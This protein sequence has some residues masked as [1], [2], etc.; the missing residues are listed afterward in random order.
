M[1]EPAVD[2][3]PAPETI[4]EEQTQTAFDMP[5]EAAAQIAEEAQIDMTAEAPEASEPVVEPTPEP[6]PEEVFAKGARKLPAVPIGK[7]VEDV[8]VTMD[9]SGN[10]S[11]IC[12]TRGDE[13]R[14]LTTRI[15]SEITA[16][17]HPDDVELWLFDCGDGEFDKYIDAPAEHIKYLISDA[18]AETSLDFADVIMSE[19]NSRTEK[20]AANNWASADDIPADVYMPRIVIAVNAFSRFIENIVKSP[21][22]FGR[23]YTSKL[24][25]MFKN[26][27]KYGV[28]FLLIGDEFSES[29]EFPSYF[30]GCTIDSAAVTS[31]NDQAAHKIFSGFKLYDNEIESLRRVPAGCAFTADGNSSDGLTLVRITGENAVNEHTYRQASEYSENVEEYLD[32]RPFI[33]GRKAASRFDDRR[34]Y[35]E[36]QI[37]NR[38]NGEYLLFLGEPNRFMGE[39][40]VH[41]YDDFGENIFAVAPAREKSSAALTVRAALRSL[42]E[43][44]VRT[45]VLAYRS[46]PVYAEL[47]QSDELAN[48]AVFEGTKADERIKEIVDMLDIGGTP[49][50]FAIV[51]GGDL[52]M[53]SM[54]ADDTL[55]ILKRALV[56][57]PRVGT[58]FMLVSGSLAHMADEFLSLFRHKLVFACPYS[59]AEKILRDPNCD[60]LENSFRLSNDYDELTILPYSM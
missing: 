12:G 46:N 24:A 53:A 17:T 1:S 13:R 35:R 5:L 11:Y 55:D 42:A 16:K 21:K 19:L 52:M 34:D 29:G 15:I 39:Y 14:K 47:M 37:N 26:S 23:N 58:H 33:G 30:E 45:E 31:G 7:T 48:V 41:L 25:K 38:N 60:L 9:I 27:A 22:F 3:T 44:G 32:K 50:V 28:H 10:I 18:G 6:E 4:P 43:Q 2:N 36:E 54:Q 8:P 49:D 51:L 20:F 59:E 56:K 57:G 40:P